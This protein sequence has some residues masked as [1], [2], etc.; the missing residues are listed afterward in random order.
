MKNKFYG[1]GTEQQIVEA[2]YNVCDANKRL[3]KVMSK[4]QLWDSYCPAFNF[5]LDA[6][7]LLAEALS[8]GFVFKLR[9]PDQYLVNPNY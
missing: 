1:Q 4:Q 3:F 2:Y 5:E 8:R 6:D 7:Q 9:E